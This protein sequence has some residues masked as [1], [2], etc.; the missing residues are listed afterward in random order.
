MQR[1]QFITLVGGTVIPWPLL[2]PCKKV[3]LAGRGSALDSGA[4]TT[5]QKTILGCGRSARL[6]AGT[7]TD[8]QGQR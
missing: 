7:R 1:R 8:D 4:S 2:L 5:Y 6:E 3:K